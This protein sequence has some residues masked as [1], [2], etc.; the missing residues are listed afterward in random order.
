MPQL[1][2][3][4]LPAPPRR[5]QYVARL[6]RHTTPPA[7]FTSRLH[8]PIRHDH[9]HPRPAFPAAHMNRDYH[10]VFRRAILLLKKAGLAV[11]LTQSSL[12]FTHHR[13]PLPPLG[14][15][16]KQPNGQ[17]FSSSVTSGFTGSTSSNGNEL[18]LR[19]CAA[20]QQA[21][22]TPRAYLRKSDVS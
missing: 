4:T 5:H 17:P 6:M 19:A 2:P 11:S 7:L 1:P 10:P 14:Q 16:L 12:V 15:P 13:L 18:P 20:T 8:P 22:T 9:N 21:P 3:A